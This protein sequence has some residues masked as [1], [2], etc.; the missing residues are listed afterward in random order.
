M[1]GMV[2]KTLVACR[3]GFSIHTEAGTNATSTVGAYPC[4]D[5]IHD[6]VRVGSVSVYIFV[7]IYVYI[8]IYECTCTCPFRR[9]HDPVPGA[10]VYVDIYIYTYMYIY[11][12]VY[13]DD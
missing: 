2:D 8:Y 12:D 6:P 7:Y 5:R 11:V 4:Q 1:L 3:D 10:I 9:M 13:I